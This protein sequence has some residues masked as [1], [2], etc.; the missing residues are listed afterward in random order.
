MLIALWILFFSQQK[1]RS[2][3]VEFVM[4]STRRSNHAIE[5]TATRRKI[6]D[7]MTTDRRPQGTLGLGSGRSSYSR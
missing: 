7:N 5:R 2:R 3:S 6:Q 4:L 1:T